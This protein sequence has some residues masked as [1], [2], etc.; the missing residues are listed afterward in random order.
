MCPIQFSKNFHGMFYNSTQFQTIFKSKRINCRKFWCNNITRCPLL[1]LDNCVH[2]S[3]GARTIRWFVDRSF[4]IAFFRSQSSV[5]SSNRWQL[6]MP[7]PSNAFKKRECLKES[8]C[9]IKCGRT[10]LCIAKN[11]FKNIE[12]HTYWIIEYTEYVCG[13]FWH[14]KWLSHILDFSKF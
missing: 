11:K 12:I 14:L 8:E 5:V 9:W 3:V 2:I 13:F 7:V 1:L 10:I 4:S 6:N